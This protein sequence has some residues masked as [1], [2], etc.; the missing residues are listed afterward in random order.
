MAWSIEGDFGVDFSALG[1]SGFSSPF[2]W[3]G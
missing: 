2:G 1:K 3:S